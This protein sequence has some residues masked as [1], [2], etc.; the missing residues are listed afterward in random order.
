MLSD[1]AAVNS[2][3]GIETRPK[4]MVADWMARAGMRD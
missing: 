3:I 4:D 2:L 1:E